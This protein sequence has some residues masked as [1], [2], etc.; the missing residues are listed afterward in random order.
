MFN[1]HYYTPSFNQPVNGWDV[2]MVTSLDSLFSQ[3]VAFNQPINAW[4]VGRVTA[5]SVRLASEPLLPC[6][7]QAAVHPALSVHVCR[8]PWCSGYIQTADGGEYGRLEQLQQAPHPRDVRCPSPVALECRI[9]LNGALG[10]RGELLARLR[11]AVPATTVNTTITTGTTVN[12]T[13]TIGTTTATQHRRRRSNV[14]RVR[15]GCLPCVHR[16]RKPKT[17]NTRH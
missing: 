16:R 6:T 2:S 11:H 12:T 13:I 10:R 9:E 17:Q 7:A 5:L 8:L 3:G 1:G 4:D 15:R 14:H